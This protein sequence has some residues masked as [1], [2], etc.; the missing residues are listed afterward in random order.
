MIFC[1]GG[2]FEKKFMLTSRT[3]RWDIHSQQDQTR[4]LVAHYFSELFAILVPLQHLMRSQFIVIYLK[5][6]VLN[7]NKLTIRDIIY[8]L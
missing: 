3:L 1:I 7:K 2:K 5:P 4:V 8:S 6:K